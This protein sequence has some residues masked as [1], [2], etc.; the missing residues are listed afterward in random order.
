MNKF[1][2]GIMQ[3][4]L[5]PKESNLYQ[6]HPSD[7]QKE[8]DLCKNNSFDYIEWIIDA[9]SIDKNPIFSISGRKQIEEKISHTNVKVKSIC[10]DLLME[11]FIKND[12]DIHTWKMYLIKII[13]SASKINAGIIVIPL[14][15]KMSLSNSNLFS[16]IL[17]ILND[18]K[19]ICKDMNIKLALELD[20][21]PKKVINVLDKLNS[22]YVG[23]NYDLGNS[24]ALGFDIKEEFN[25]YGNKIFDIH[26]KDRCFNSGP[27]LLGTGNVDFIEAAKLIRKNKNNCPIIMQSYRNHEGLNITILQKKWFEL[28]LQND[29]EN[30]NP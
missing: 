15:E 22:E 10:A 23:I 27:C 17:K 3:G 4:R 29:Y 11:K 28:I 20:L 26:I 18:C 16:V 8:F 2:L 7:W 9:R 12:K 13:E 6:C 14:I 30:R 25:Y 24:A 1:S 21:S 19:E 5:L